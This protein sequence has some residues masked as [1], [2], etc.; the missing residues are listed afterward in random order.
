MNLLCPSR[1]SS[2]NRIET[3]FG[4]RNVPKKIALPISPTILTS[5]PNPFQGSVSY[6]HATFSEYDFMFAGHYAI[7]FNWPE[8]APIVK[9]SVFPDFGESVIAAPLWLLEQMRALQQMQPPTLDDVDT[10][11]KAA[12]EIRRKLIGN[13]PPF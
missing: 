1:E 9:E 4:V 13:Q 8:I 11:L 3:Y 6:R 2:A 10:Q 12:A 7:L 5:N